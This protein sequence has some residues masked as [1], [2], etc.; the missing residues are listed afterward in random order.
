MFVKSL[1]MILGRLIGTFTEFFK[2][3]AEETETQFIEAV[4]RTV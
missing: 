1:T 2:L 4:N 3:G